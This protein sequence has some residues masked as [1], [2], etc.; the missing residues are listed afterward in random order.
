MTLSF[1]SYR[2]VKQAVFTTKTIRLMLLRQAIAASSD[3]HAKYIIA[4]CGKNAG[5]FL[6]VKQVMTIP[7]T[8][9]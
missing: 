5:V 1:N 6:L 9:P 7:T 4:L 3:N 2:T 8:E